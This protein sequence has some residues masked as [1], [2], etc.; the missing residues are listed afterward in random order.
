MSEPTPGR[1]RWPRPKRCQA[2]NGGKHRW[3]PRI[4]RGESAG[5]AAQVRCPSKQSNDSS[6]QEA[7]RG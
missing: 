5:S 3:A 2:D 7:D 4:E 6:S 1:V